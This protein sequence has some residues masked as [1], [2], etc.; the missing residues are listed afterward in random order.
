MSRL[1][2]A[3]SGLVI[4]PVSH[5][6]ET[7]SAGR[8][9]RELLQVQ[10]GNSRGSRGAVPP[11]TASAHRARRAACSSAVSGAPRGGGQVQRTSSPLSASGEIGLEVQQQL[12]QV[13]APLLDR[14]GQ[15]PL[16]DC[17]APAS[18]RQY[19]RARTSACTSTR[20]TS[21]PAQAGG[22]EEEAYMSW[23]H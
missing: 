1:P 4:V 15:R 5:S 10:H 22:R 13:L 20:S 6:L 14:D 12:N 17:I 2:R 11:C 8:G 3:L 23:R 16:P 18:E 9:S 7:M 21:E 19:I